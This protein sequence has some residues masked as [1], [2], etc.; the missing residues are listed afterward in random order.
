MLTAPPLKLAAAALAAEAA[1]R[2][3]RTVSGPRLLSSHCATAGQQERYLGIVGP[4]LAS[5]GPS[6]HTS[7]RAA[8]RDG[9]SVAG[10][11]LADA[12]GE[13][14]SGCQALVSIACRRVEPYGDGVGRRRG[15]R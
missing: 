7:A 3:L 13:R 14:D 12:P 15:R 5:R 4:F 6:C 9:R 10:V 1:A 8:A 11:L 2:A